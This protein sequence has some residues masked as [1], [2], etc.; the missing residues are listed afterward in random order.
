[1]WTDLHDS[2]H[3]HPNDEIPGAATFFRVAEALPTHYQ[4]QGEDTCTFCLLVCLAPLQNHLQ[5]GISMWASCSMSAVLGE[6]ESGATV[7]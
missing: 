4:L 7:L 1:M 6:F 2:T 3:K 5:I